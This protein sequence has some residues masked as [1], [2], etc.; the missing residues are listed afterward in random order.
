MM[1]KIF[2][3]IIIISVIFGILSGNTSSLTT[4]LLEDGV[5]AVELWI[6]ML[7]G[8]CVWGGIM[9]VAEKSGVTSYISALFRPL[10]KRLFKNSCKNKSILNSVSMN[11]TANLLGIGNAATPL[12]IDAMRKMSAE[13][14]LSD[15]ASDD[16]IVFTVLNTASITL[17]PSTAAS[18]RM[19]H[20][21]E[22]PLD[23]MPAVLVNSII[24]VSVALI[25]A[26]V[27]NKLS[28]GKK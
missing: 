21:A 27:L 11:I 23:I 25:T 8:M 22:N 1:N 2:S 7:G 26:I 3:I 28:G 14:P 5:N 18:L 19:K 24:S 9:R 12:G 15:T 17:I 20:G 13:N 16:M 4:S 10:L 6:Y